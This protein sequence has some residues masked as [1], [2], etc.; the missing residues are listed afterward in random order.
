MSARTLLLKFVLPGKEVVFFSVFFC[1]EELYW[2][3]FEMKDDKFR[4]QKRGSEY[5]I[6]A[7]RFDSEFAFLVGVEK[8]ALSFVS[9][10]WLA[11]FVQSF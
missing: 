11:F 5:Q 7:E 9:C 6:C 8:Y 2:R 10:N 3:T 4:A 1:G